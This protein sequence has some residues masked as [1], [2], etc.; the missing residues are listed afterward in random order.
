MNSQS[1]LANATIALRDQHDY[2]AWFDQLQARCKA[3]KV[4]DQV[5]PD[6]ATAPMAE[7]IEPE[8]PDISEYTPAS[9]LADGI[10]PTRLS[11]LSSSGQ[12]AYKDD[13]EIYKLYMEKYKVRYA[14]YKTESVNLQHI[15][16]LIQ[17]TVSQY[18]QRTCCSPDQPLKQWITNLQAEAGST[19]DYE[20]KIARTR[21]RMALKPPRSVTSWDIWLT[22]YNQAA[23]EAEVLQV[24]EVSQI[25]EVAE[26]F[27][28]AV[29]KIAPSWVASHQFQLSA[30][31][32]SQSNQSRRDMINS[33]RQN[34]MISQPITRGRSQKVALVVED[35]SHLTQEI[36]STQ[37]D[38]DA[39]GTQRGDSH[40]YR[41]KRGIPYEPVLEEGAKS[42]Q[43][44]Q[45]P[46]R[47]RGNLAK[48]SA[49]GNSAKAD[50]SN[51]S[52]PIRLGTRSGPQC[53]ACEMKHAIRDCFYVHPNKA[54][55][56][57][58]PNPRTAQFVELRLDHDTEFQ[59]LIRAQSRPRIVSQAI[60]QSQTPQPETEDQ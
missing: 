25:K 49:Y 47:G 53:P 36:K 23:K 45:Y 40:T 11:D 24:P 37:V 41:L 18:L 44:K 43:G 57:W 4:W 30:L 7:P 16:A 19:Q 10:T 21:Y 60:K 13:L 50:A 32:E 28:M 54:P 29:E 42:T 34:M 33:F 15:V 59:S 6:S 55:E 46:Q 27:Y 35:S 26:D 22:E 5:N 2:R 1:T 20:R 56:W 8:I 48:A 51:P 12:R 17:A 9:A 14:A 39:R 31:K 38:G 58:K 52:K 3:H